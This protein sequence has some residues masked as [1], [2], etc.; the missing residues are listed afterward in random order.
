[1]PWKAS[2][3]FAKNPT[4]CYFASLLML[5]RFTLFDNHQKMSHL[6]SSLNCHMRFVV[7]WDYMSDFQNTVFLLI[8][9]WAKK[10]SCAANLKQLT[11]GVVAEEEGKRKIL[12]GIKRG[13]AKVCTFWSLISVGPHKRPPPI[14]FYR[15]AH[16]WRVL[17]T[18]GAGDAIGLTHT[19]LQPQK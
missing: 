3:Y 16:I 4:F 5:L 9:F 1:M 17:P 19:V 15:E 10:S 11:G 12:C 7:K 8:S 13:L 6:K 14:A 2:I 18:Y